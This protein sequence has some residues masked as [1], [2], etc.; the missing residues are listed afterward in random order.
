MQRVLHLISC[1][2]FKL[3]HLGSF[4]KMWCLSSSLFSIS[5]LHF[6]SYI[7]VIYF[8]ATSGLSIIIRSFEDWK[9]FQSCL[10]I[11]HQWMWRTSDK[12][13]IIQEGHKYL[14]K[15]QHFSK[16]FWTEIELC[17]WI[18]KLLCQTWNL[19]IGKSLTTMYLSITYTYKCIWFIWFK[20]V[21]QFHF[22]KY[23]KMKIECG[24]YTLPLW[25]LKGNFLRLDL[26]GN[27]LWSA[28]LA[29][30]QCWS[31]EDKSQLG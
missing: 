24:S 5:R 6:K 3:H 19:C 21:S 2:V 26:K 8:R 18:E 10:S 25:W 11:Y 30:P 16:Y 28:E 9:H 4:I 14:K 27:C 22:E 7:A 17:K 31:F 13:Q 1:H 12:V 15:Y 20:L 23:G 29:G